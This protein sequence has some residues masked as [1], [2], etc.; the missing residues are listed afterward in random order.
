MFS[1]GDLRFRQPVPSDPY[2]GTFQATSFGNACPQQAFK[3]DIPSQAVSDVVNEVINGF[4]DLITPA[5][6]DC[7]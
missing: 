6:E 2:T 5:S 3:F 7:K 4:Y 1:T